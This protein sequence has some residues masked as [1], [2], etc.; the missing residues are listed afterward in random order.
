MSLNLGRRPF[1]ELTTCSLRMVNNQYHAHTPDS[2]QC[3]VHMKCEYAFHV[4]SC[5]MHNESYM[6]HYQN[7]DNYIFYILFTSINRAYINLIFSHTACYS[8][9]QQHTKWPQSRTHKNKS[10]LGPFTTMNHFWFHSSSNHCNI[11]T[12]NKTQGHQ[13]RD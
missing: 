3:P 4:I 8:I 7:M 6:K 9:K 12:H 11:K 10:P 5:Y 13:S 1:S 2:T